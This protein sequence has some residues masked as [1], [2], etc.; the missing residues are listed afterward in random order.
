M[1]VPRVAKTHTKTA[2]SQ[3]NSVA[4]H[5]LVARRPS[6]DWV[7]H[8]APHLQKAEEL[9]REAPP[10]TLR[11]DFSK[12]PIFPPDSANRLKDG[13]ADERNAD[14]TAKESPL[15]V[16]EETLNAPGQSLDPEIRN[17]TEARFGCDFSEVKVHTDARAAESARR[18]NALAYTSGN[19][20]AFDAGQYA[21]KTHTGM[22]LLS[23][24]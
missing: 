12:I 10:L 15:Q 2:A 21:P 23:M 17:F 9:A 14:S 7:E 3:T 5:A 8:R 4:R 16:V 22:Q 1:F 24:S 11:W 19:H 13:A 18:V 6:Y 20:I